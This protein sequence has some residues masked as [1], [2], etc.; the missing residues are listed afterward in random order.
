M[1]GIALRAGRFTGSDD[2]GEISHGHSGQRQQEL[3]NL[4]RLQLPP[5]AINKKL[6]SRAPATSPW[7]GLGPNLATFR[8][9]REAQSSK[10]AWGAP[11]LARIAIVALPIRA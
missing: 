2:E 11:I 5:V 4:S 9:A 6:Q 3:R 8:L 1:R 10:H 7:D